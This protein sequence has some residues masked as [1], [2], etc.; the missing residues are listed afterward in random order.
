M[1]EDFGLKPSALLSINHYMAM[2]YILFVLCG[3][4]FTVSRGKVQSDG[5]ARDKMGDHPILKVYKT[6]GDIEQ[7]MKLY[8]TPYIHLTDPETSRMY[9]QLSSLL[10]TRR[11]SCQNPNGQQ[12]S[13]RGASVYVRGYYEADTPDHIIISADCVS[14]SR[15]PRFFTCLRTY[16]NHIC[17]LRALQDT[18]LRFKWREKHCTLSY[19]PRVF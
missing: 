11:M 9:P 4:D 13:K 10:A 12:L 14:Q 3:I 8:N 15:Y 19:V 17:L 16:M 2:R 5:D 18:T 1:E 6:L 7:G